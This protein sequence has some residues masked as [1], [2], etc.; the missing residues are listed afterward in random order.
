MGR[1]LVVCVR[2]YIP[3]GMLKKKKPAVTLIIK[4]TFKAL[5][6]YLCYLHVCMALRAIAMGG[7]Y[8]DNACR[9]TGHQ[10]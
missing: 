1:K 3:S 6:V 10:F 9:D 7:P 8:C 2:Y 4:S 5:L